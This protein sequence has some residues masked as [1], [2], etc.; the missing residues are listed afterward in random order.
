MWLREGNEE[1]C[2]AWWGAAVIRAFGRQ[3]QECQEYIVN[4][5]LS[6]AT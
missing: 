4:P 1:V 2:W 5:G 6:W 3:R